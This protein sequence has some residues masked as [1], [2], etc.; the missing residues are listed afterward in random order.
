MNVL[1]SELL[2]AHSSGNGY[3][4]SKLLSPL[5]PPGEPNRLLSI[6]KSTNASSVKKDVRSLFR[7]YLSPP[8]RI[9]QD[10]VT[11]WVEI[12]SAYWKAIGDVLAVE[13]R[14]TGGMGVSIPPLSVPRELKYPSMYCR[15]DI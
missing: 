6:W 11:G 13:G 12:F 8:A 7:A 1:I 3:D 9:S 5:S 14:E 2:V 4:V 15:Y 10:E